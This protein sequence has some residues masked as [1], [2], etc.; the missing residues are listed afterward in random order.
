MQS[1]ADC[2][3]YKLYRFDGI[4]VVGIRGAEKFAQFEFVFEFANIRRIRILKMTGKFAEFEFEFEHRNSNSNRIMFPK[5][6]NIRR[7]F[8]FA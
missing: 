7:E 4:S 8:E 5:F 1:L 6:E 3:A 2:D